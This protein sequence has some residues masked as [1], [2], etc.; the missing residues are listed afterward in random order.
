M[1]MIREYEARHDNDECNCMFVPSHIDQ[2][3]TQKMK[4]RQSLISF[5]PT[6]QS[7]GVSQVNP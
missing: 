2:L 3:W 1:I 4:N 6:S 7:L 5:I